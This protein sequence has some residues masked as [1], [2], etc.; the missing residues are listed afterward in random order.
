MADTQARKYQLTVNNPS[1]KGLDH[2]ELKRRLAQLK[3]TVYWC[4]ADEV[5]LETGTP[6]THIFVLFRSP[7]QFSR[8]HKLLP[9]AHIERVQGFSAENKAYV[10]KSGK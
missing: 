6:H 5:G 8:L 4:M 1:A 3:S 7:V 2:D 10:E 9:D